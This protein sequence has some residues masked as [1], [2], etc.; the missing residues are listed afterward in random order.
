MI[1]AQSLNYF[2]NIAKLTSTL[3]ILL[4]VI[5]VGIGSV[6]TTSEQNP[7]GLSICLGEGYQNFF[8]GQSKILWCNY[9][10]PIGKF[11]CSLFIVL[12]VILMSNLIDI[13]CTYLISNAINSQTEA[14]KSMIGEKAYISRKK[15]VDHIYLFFVLYR[16]TVGLQ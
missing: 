6:G 15:Y 3:N 12:Q 1:C 14:M 16:P 4:P 8:S 7:P 11:A 10:N 5:S 13:Y 2:Q 9:Y